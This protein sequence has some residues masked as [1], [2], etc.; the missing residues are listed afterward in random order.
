MPEIVYLLETSPYDPVTAGLKTANF[1]SNL[2]E[3]TLSGSS[4]PYP[5]RLSSV[6]SH[7][8]SVYENNLPGQANVS[9]GTSVI[10]NADGRFD[11]LINYNWDNRDVAI[12][13][14]IRG[15]A[16]G[17]FTTEFV[18]KTIELNADSGNL[19]L[20]LKDNSLKLSKPMQTAK[21]AGTSGA[22]GGLELKG[23]TKPLLYSDVRN[24]APVL[25]DSAKLT[26]QLH[27]GTLTS[28]SKVYD[29]AN[30]LTFSANYASYSLLVDAI[31]PPGNYATC[32]ASGYIRL[33]APP[34]GTVT[35]DAQGPK[36]SVY[37]ATQAYEMIKALGGLTAGDFDTASITA[38]DT[39]FSYVY[40]GLYFPEPDLQLD[41]FLEIIATSMDAF[42]YVTRAGLIK[43]Q[44]F[45]FRSPS[46]VV[47]Q[48]DITALG[49]SSSPLPANKVRVNYAKNA[50][51]QSIDDFVIP[52]QTF[53]GL[54]TKSHQFIAT[55]ADGSGGTYT[56]DAVFKVF[57][58]EVEIND[59]GIVQFSV[60][61][62]SA[63]VTIDALGVISITNPGVTS[64]T[65]TL[66]AN[67]GEFNVDMD[68]T[69][70]RSL[71][72]LKTI[73]L[74]PNRNHVLID[75]AGAIV[76]GDQDVDMTVAASGT[77]L[78]TISGQDNLG[79]V[80]NPSNPSANVYRISDTEVVNNPLVF[81]IKWS[82]SDAAGLK[83]T[84][85]TNIRRGTDAY[86]SSILSAYAV[87]DGSISLFYQ[88]T[89]PLA[90]V[91]SINDLWFDTDDS[92]K[93]YRYDGS[94]WGLAADTRIPTAL[95]NA[96]AA[97]TTADTKVKTFFAATG[98]PPTATTVG[99]LWYN[100]DTKKLSRWSGSA[101]VDVSSLVVQGTDIGVANNAGTTNSLILHTTGAGASTRTGNTLTKSGGTGAFNTAWS[102]AEVTTGNGVV[103][104]KPNGN[105]IAFTLVKLAEVGAAADGLGIY[106]GNTANIYFYED[107]S[108]SASIGTFTQGVDTLSFEYDGVIA[109]AYKN[110]VLLSTYTPNVSYATAQLRAQVF[111]YATTTSVADFLF[112]PNSANNFSIIGGLSRP[113]DYAGTTNSFVAFG[114][115]VV[116]RQGNSLTK[117]SGGSGWNAGYYTTEG[118]R[119]NG[120]I[121]ARPTLANR[122]SMVLL[123]PVAS[124]TT[125]IT[126]RGLYFNSDG[127]VYFWPSVSL[128]GSYVAD[129]AVSGV[130]DG[131]M[132]RFFKNGNSFGSTIADTTYASNDLVCQINFELDGTALNAVQFM[133]Y[134]ANNFSSIGGDTR[135]ADNATA[136]MV[137]TSVGSQ[138]VT[139]IGNSFK[140][141]SGSGD[142]TA[143]VRGEAMVNMAYAE[144]D[145]NQ[146]ASAYT[147]VA[148]D[149]AAGGDAFAAMNF[150]LH[151]VRSSGSYVAYANGASIG[152][153]GTLATNL[154][155]K[156]AIAY[157][158]VSFKAFIAGAQV[159]A[160]YSTTVNQTL[161]PKWH[162]YTGDAIGVKGM[163]HLTYT[164]NNFTDIGGTTKPE[165]NAS[166]DAN[167][168]ADNPVIIFADSSG[169]PKTGEIDKIVLCKLFRLGTALTS[170][171]TW[172]A[173][174][175]T[176]N[177]TF[178]IS[179][180]GTGTLTITGPN[181]STMAVESIIRLTG[182]YL[183]IARTL[184]I[185]VIRQDDPP[186]SSGGGSGNPGTSAS[187]TSLGNTVGSSFPGTA[188]STLTCKAGTGGQV[189]C[190]FP[191]SYKRN[192]AS[193]VGTSTAT[194][195]WQWRVVAG[196]WADI[197]AGDTGDIA[198]TVNEPP[199]INEAGTGAFNATKTGLTSGTDYEF[200]FL[201]H[202]T[203][204]T[205][206]SAIELYRSAGTLLVSGS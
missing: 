193:A 139:I 122:T 118:S 48:E 150:T 132:W 134:T 63:W 41:E 120:I 158:G 157:D 196:S 109:R 62:T 91:S 123:T 60:L 52:R 117:V 21:F 159:G 174:L 160:S 130:Y 77:T 71:G 103:A 49:R 83:Q 72:A 206:T 31:I 175:I 26:Y 39:D 107:G 67:L 101:W 192:T 185:K 124:R 12:K 162:D 205:G 156:I 98:S 135:P 169:A 114:A 33:G 30:P 161:W 180:T 56:T 155:G 113:S 181:N 94:S 200:Q 6:Y 65:A 154:T 140:R 125:A 145:I 105:D 151:F 147:M 177:A 148:L 53:N 7:E 55:A 57:L 50:T 23:R 19:V 78:T 167:I 17:T 100:T 142:Y 170:G 163:R 74:T 27:N 68:F 202:R 51:V 127:N 92:N 36:Y 183:S 37:L 129:D 24:A 141:N 69:V 168:S 204:V 32:L 42:W 64:A 9:I 43:I 171:V 133:P 184:D 73:T 66:R 76:G 46:V 13:K 87:G 95:S 61:S 80:Y 164:Q 18:G 54:L 116:S 195:K 203:T 179:G 194:G 189:A 176:G 188:S 153:S 34:E 16:Y 182:S 84:R 58:N 14:G 86:A 126:G 131:V 79:T 110:G 44:Q 25:L 1:S 40:E 29:K 111:L 166:I 75:D 3:E 191:G 28:V 85:F 10:N 137:F 15:A 45:K 22:E 89:A 149:D 146:T 187:T 143:C 186:T 106:V 119:G 93:V 5:V 81:W 97:Q 172:A 190:T 11:F 178:S 104:C 35:A 59:Y 201:W 144:V 47:R 112:M 197:D 20:V 138:S 4:N 152:I 136:D 128:I 90:G 38:M 88:T 199:V 70:T 2:L 165:S 108:L 82:A 173:S 102:T 99:D 96:A 8:S 115:G 121:S 198:E